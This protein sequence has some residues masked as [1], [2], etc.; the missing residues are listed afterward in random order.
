MSQSDQ[1]NR[2]N[3]TKIRLSY[4]EQIQ[5]QSYPQARIFHLHRF[6]PSDEIFQHLL[7]AQSPRC[8]VLEWAHPFELSNWIKQITPPRSG[9]RWFENWQ[10]WENAT[11]NIWLTGPSWNPTKPSRL[12]HAP[13]NPRRGF[14]IE[15]RHPSQRIHFRHAVT[16][17]T[18][19]N[20]KFILF[21]RFYSEKPSQ[22]LLYTPLKLSKTFHINWMSQPLNWKEAKSVSHSAASCFLIHEGGG[23]WSGGWEGRRETT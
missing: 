3:Q 18:F 15:A 20:W 17:K 21:C 9:G 4:R 22:L 8:D 11:A 10:A 1:P 13:H 14:S 6:L 16:L 19:A 23:G 7:F 5:L 2:V 12:S